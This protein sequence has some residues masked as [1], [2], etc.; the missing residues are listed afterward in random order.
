MRPWHEFSNAS[1][2]ANGAGRDARIKSVTRSDPTRPCTNG[3]ELGLDLVGDASILLSSE[4]AGFV[5]GRGWFVRGLDLC[6][7]ATKGTWGMSWRQEAL[8]GV[9]VCDKL[10]GIDKRILIPRFP[11]WQPLNP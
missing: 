6:G 3:A 4:L 11:N 1:S 9:E 5:I 10:G 8:K 2:K 7:Q